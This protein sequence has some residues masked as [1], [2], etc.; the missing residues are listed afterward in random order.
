M[1][2]P[3]TRVLIVDG[4]AVSV[5]AAAALAREEQCEAGIARSLA[6]AESSLKQ[7]STDLLVL[8]SHLPDGSGLDLLERVD[9][10]RYGSVVV[11]TSKPCLESA[12]RAVTAPVVE[13]LVKPVHPGRLRKLFR[14]AKPARIIAS[15]AQLMRTALI[16]QSRAIRE[17]VA[18]LLKVAPTNASVLL[19]GES[20]TGK[21][22]AARTLHDTSD[23]PGKFVAVSCGAMAAKLLAY[24]IP[25][26]QR[27]GFSGAAPRQDGMLEQ[28]T[29]GTLLL[30]DV[31]E[32]PPPFQASLLRALES[33]SSAQNGGGP[34]ATAPA[35]II[36]SSSRDPLQAVEEGRLRED[37]YYRL[38]EVP[39][40]MPPLRDRGE[41]IVLLA[42]VFI[43]RLNAF[44][45]RHKRLAHACERE[46]M[47]YLWPGNVREL[48]S[49][50]QR[51]YLLDA[52]DCVFVRPN[53]RSIG[54]IEDSETS[55]VFSV[56]MRF[57]EVEKQ[58]LLKTLAHYGNDKTATARALGIS[59]RTVHNHLARL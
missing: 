33:S 55:V 51:A 31:A 32:L 12:V 48:R 30:D 17:V 37:L 58:M 18:T 22:L 7:A 8:E 59:V 57:A 43:D 46:L 45:G 1:F 9:A 24:Q 15:D 25:E 13:Y 49:A 4:D 3:K 47:R 50:V 26:K 2:T 56:G 28:A 42:R 27:N 44:H 21:E 10:S 35:R 54:V 14:D 36:A 16:G 11:L 38:A 20:G 23:R 19:T 6:E 53:E 40:H 29:G 41:D 34:S 39:V 5:E 52:S